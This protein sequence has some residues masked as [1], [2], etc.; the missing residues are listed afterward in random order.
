METP[1]HACSDKGYL[2]IAS[3]RDAPTNFNS[4]GTNTENFDHHVVSHGSW[5]FLTPLKMRKHKALSGAVKFSLTKTDNR[6]PGKGTN[7]RATYRRK[8]A[9][10]CAVINSLVSEIAQCAK[11]MMGL[12]EKQGLVEDVKVIDLL[13]DALTGCSGFAIATVAAHSYPQSTH[14]NSACAAA[15]DTWTSFC[16]FRPTVEAT[17]F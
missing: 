5:H 11:N 6:R 10:L 4:L 1:A 17:L 3:T 15:A 8:S 9:L 14:N 12:G 2:A 7:F 13:S 16:C